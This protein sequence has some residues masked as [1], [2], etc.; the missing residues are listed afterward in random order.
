MHKVSLTARSSYQ[1]VKFPCSE[2]I[3][4]HASPSGPI[5]PQRRVT[6]GRVGAVVVTNT[7]V[8]HHHRALYQSAGWAL[9]AHLSGAGLMRRAA[10]GVCAQSTVPE[11]VGMS[12][13]AALVNKPNGA[14]WR[15]AGLAPPLLSPLWR[16][17]AQTHTE[18]RQVREK[19]PESNSMILSLAGNRC[20]E[21]KFHARLVKA[22]FSDNISGATKVKL[23]VMFMSE[24]AKAHTFF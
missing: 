21:V 14:W 15:V 16:Q 8:D 13:V 1:S 20:R 17:R 7:W 2:W 5:A 24:T 4:A 23:A 9:E 11:L 3:S 22:H 6:E 18:E 19:I 12:A 10:A